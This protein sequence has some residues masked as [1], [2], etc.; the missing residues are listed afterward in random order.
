[1]GDKYIHNGFDNPVMEHN[2]EV[3]GNAVQ[4]G[5]ASAVDMPE[6]VAD[7]KGKDKG[8]EEKKEPEKTVGVA[9]MVGIH[10]SLFESVCIV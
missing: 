7:S 9:S 8:V 5:H 1:M 6:K 2:M 10:I 4:N 3:N